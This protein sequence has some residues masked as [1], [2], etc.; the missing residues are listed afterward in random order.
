MSKPDVR[1]ILVSDALGIDR[2]AAARQLGESG[3]PSALHVLLGVLAQGNRDRVTETVIE[4]LGHLGQTEAIEPLLAFLD[5]ADMPPGLRVAG[6]V[7]LGNLGHPKYVDILAYYLKIADLEVL[8]FAQVEDSYTSAH[9]AL[10]Q[11]LARSPSSVP[12]AILEKIVNCRGCIRFDVIE[13]FGERSPR[14]FAL[15]ELDAL[16][17]A[18]L[19]RRGP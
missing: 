8:D 1:E 15:G 9:A 13:A 6:A 12:H 18:E 3:D 17:R 10:K 7:A 11:L 2:C 4:A 14:V 19:A 5:P 16:A